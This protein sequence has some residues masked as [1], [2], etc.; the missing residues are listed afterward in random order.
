M[1]VERA[2][3]ERAIAVDT[4]TLFT[5]ADHWLTPHRN[6]MGWASE[7]SWGSNAIQHASFVSEPATIAA[8]MTGPILLE[9]WF[10][11][12]ELVRGLLTSV[13]LRGST[14]K[15]IAETHAS[16]DVELAPQLRHLVLDL[17]MFRA[18]IE[19]GCTTHLTLRRGEEDS[20]RRGL[21]LEEQFPATLQYFIRSEL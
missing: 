8:V 17:G 4:V 16:H 10:W 14:S 9:G 20:I 7:V 5:A 12:T 15:T 18:P 3:P 2:N 1:P 11:A 21:R 19:P 13:V 6:L